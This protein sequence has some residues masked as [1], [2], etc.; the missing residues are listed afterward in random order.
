ML[1]VNGQSIGDGTLELVKFAETASA[2][3]EIT[4]TNADTTNAP[5]ISATGDDTDIDLRLNTKGTGGVVFNAGA[6]ATPSITTTGDTNT[7]I[8]F[9]SA[10][11]IAFT[12]GG[13]EA[14]RIDSSGD[15]GIGTTDPI[16]KL[17]VS[18]SGAFGTTALIE[19]ITTLTSSP[20]SA[21]RI[22]S[23]ST[24]NMVDGFATGIQFNL[25]DNADVINQVGAIV[26]SRDGA[27]NSG[28]IIL[29]TYNSGSL[30]TGLTI[31]KTGAVDVPGSLSKGSGSFKIDHPL[32]E[33]KDT[34]HLV[35]SFTESPQ[36]D[37][38]YRGKITLVNG[39]ATV[40][41][42]TVAGMT[43]GTFVLLN[44]EVQCFTTNETGWTAVKGSVSG[45]TLTITAQDNNCNDI[46]SW[47]VIG[48]RQDQHMYDTEWT[49]K[50]GKVIV[51]PLKEARLTALES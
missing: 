7:G 16:G 26:V 18:T 24:G 49:D 14:M 38:L 3:N 50:N 4:I 37:L 33:K 42:D 46:I 44:R 29:Y 9:P 35:H 8:F 34:H 23:T 21:F 39:T 20:T 13:T 27:D 17:H 51:E 45:N 2:V 1:D 30:T 11:T 12:E 43:E 6:V 36:A 19:R 48:E 47:L 5:E 31:S 32:P 10:D 28:K 41:I 25:R 40:N 22:L 15:V